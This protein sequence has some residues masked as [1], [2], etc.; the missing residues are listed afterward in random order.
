[1]RIVG[2]EFRGRTLTAPE[3]NNIRPTTDRVRES[4]FNVL[5]HAQ[6]SPLDGTRVLDLFCGTGALGIEAISRGAKFCLFVDDGA[7]SRGIVRTNVEDFGLTGRSK[8]YRRDATD[9]GPS[10]TMGRFDLVFADPPYRKG[11][12]E[13]A[14]LS[15]ASNGWLNNGAII[16][17]EE[18][19]DAT[20][21]LDPS[22]TLFDER[23][24]GDTIIRLARWAGK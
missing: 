2:G 17:L 1:M 12:G 19:A 8:I 15:A 20:V 4:L 22:F 13:K 5:Q 11:L 16:V 21:D 7:E 14:L 6:G 9:L 3:S 24:Y 18:A 10:G 23:P